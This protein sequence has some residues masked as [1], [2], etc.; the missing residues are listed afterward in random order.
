MTVFPRGWGGWKDGKQFSNGK[1]NETLK[2]TNA[3]KI[4]INKNSVCPVLKHRSPVLSEE[5]RFL[6]K[7]N[8]FKKIRQRG[9]ETVRYLKS[10]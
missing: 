6:T 5:E 8:T 9:F 3:Q 7:R 4:Q 1:P 10:K 2:S